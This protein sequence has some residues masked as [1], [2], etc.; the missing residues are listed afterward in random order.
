MFVTF[1]TRRTGVE[2]TDR[3][4]DKIDTIESLYSKIIP[5]CFSLAL[6]LSLYHPF[7]LSILITLYSLPPL[8]SILFYLL[9]SSFL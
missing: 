2:Q 9:S 1:H 5:P 7:S 6:S 4:T 3:Q 8:F